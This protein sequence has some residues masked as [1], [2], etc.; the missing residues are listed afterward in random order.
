METKDHRSI[1]LEMIITDMK[2]DAEKFDGQPFTGR[3]VAEY[4]GNLGAAIA[5]LAKIIGSI[6][7]QINK[8]TNK[9]DFTT[10]SET[11]PWANLKSN[12]DP[13]S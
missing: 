1:V 12:P 7:E 13:E 5:A 9:D 8:E 10:A 3:T 11:T 6:L 2:K 4:N